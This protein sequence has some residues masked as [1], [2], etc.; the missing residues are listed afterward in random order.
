MSCYALFDFKSSFNDAKLAQFAHNIWARMSDNPRFA[1]IKPLVDTQLKQNLDAFVAVVQEAADGSRVKHAEKRARRKELLDVLE[2]LA[3]QVSTLAAGDDSV[4][5]D[6]GF[7]VRPKPTRRE[8]PDIGQVQGLHVS[9]GI[10]PGEVL[11]SFPGV[12]R[13]L[14]YAAEWSADDGQ[15][16]QNGTY[17]S[18]RRTQLGGLPQRAE[19][20]F[21]VTAIGAG[22]RKGAPSIP[23][24]QF[25]I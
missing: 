18:A 17:S 23:V 2:T 25:V 3:G 7:S 15:T 22:Q 20:L 1:G 4:I 14:V 21:R 5:L 24:R 9:T 11:L 6:A 16:W 13:A 10:R 12:P 8:L 19:L